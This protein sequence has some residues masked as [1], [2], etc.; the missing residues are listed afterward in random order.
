[1]SIFDQLF[2]RKQSTQAPMNLPPVEFIRIGAD[3]KPVEK[4][5]VQVQDAD[6]LGANTPATFAKIFVEFPDVGGDNRYGTAEEINMMA[7]KA[8]DGYTRALAER[9]NEKPVKNLMKLVPVLLGHGNTEA[10]SF[11]IDEKQRD[12]KGN[13]IPGRAEGP[14]GFDFHKKYY[15]KFLKARGTEDSYEEAANYIYDILYG[16]QMQKIEGKPI[17]NSRF[18]KAIVD[19]IETGDIEKISD[20]MFKGFFDPADQSEEKR[21]ERLRDTQSFQK[22]LNF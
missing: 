15:R 6:M 12:A 8:S 3:N 5:P 1:M 19:A 10:P 2:G 16:K 17:L 22:Q 14:L 11:K 9:A 13:P 4:P 7:Q 18:K 21:L 20:A